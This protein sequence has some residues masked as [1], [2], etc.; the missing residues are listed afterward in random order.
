MR[1]IG[2]FISAALASSVALP[3]WALA[4]TAAGAQQTAEDEQEESQ[5]KPRLQP[6]AVGDAF[7]LGQITVHGGTDGGTSGQS[8]SQSIVTSDDVRTQNRNTLDDALRTTPGVQVSNSGG[9]RNER[10]IYVRGFDRWQVPLS[11]DGVRIYLPADNRI[12]VGRFL[13]PDLAEIQVQKGYVSVLNGPGGMG[14]QINL[15]T[16]KPT[17]ELEGEMR[18][19]FDIGNTGD[20]AAYTLFGSLGTRQELYYLQVNGSLRDSDGWFLSRNYDPVPP[21]GGGVPVQGPGRRDFSQV[22]DWRIN[23]KAGLTP[24][25][26]DEYV[27]S[28]THQEGAKGAPYHVRDNVRGITTGA[29]GY[30]NNWTWPYWNVSSTAFNSHTEIGE[31]SYVRTKAYYNTFD[32]LLSAFDDVNFNSQSVRGFDSYYD[33][34]AYGFS[35]EGGTELIP[36]NTLKATVHYRRDTH[37]NTDNEWPGRTAGAGYPAGWTGWEPT[38]QRS[39]DTWSVAAENTFHATDT[40]DLVAGLSYD[41]QKTIRAEFYTPPTLPPGQGSGGSPGGTID[42]A[43]LTSMDALN[44]Q[45]AAIWQATPDLE[46]HASVSAR[47]RFPNL[48]ERYS[49][50]FLTNIPNPGLSSERATNYEIGGTATILEGDARIGGAV[51]YNDVS[52]AIISVSG[53]SCAPIGGTGTNCTQAQNVGK[54]TYY[55][56]EVSGEWDVLSSLTLGGNYTLLKSELENPSSPTLRPEGRPEH[57]AYLYAHWR[58]IEKLTISP[59]VELSSKRWSSIGGGAYR[60]MPGFGLVNLNMEYAFNDQASLTLGVRNILDKHYELRDGFPEPGRTFYVNTRFT[61]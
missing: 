46:L 24:N 57:I 22:N 60:E 43:A 4:Q 53:L 41:T 6:A 39:E 44:W 36:M 17:R 18:A 2:V 14:G 38:V 45:G 40:F 28:Y 35:L 23:V 48:F 16:R 29:P 31:A 21:P 33:D 50:R 30:Q 52:N 3:G 5:R 12:D 34:Y 7:V 11:I 20:L 19:G 27:L 55:G 51:F 26:T 61:F 37:R 13:T 42:S 56:F 47:T 32:N 25:A 59:G 10:M 15:V 58:P 49:T 8:P 1:Y 54:A 9:Q